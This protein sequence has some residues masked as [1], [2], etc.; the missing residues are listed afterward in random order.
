MECIEQ[1]EKSGT[2]EGS[3]FKV[4]GTSSHKLHIAPF[5]LDLPS[6][7]GRAPRRMLKKAVLVVRER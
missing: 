6:N 3:R 5:S 2:G 4:F 7:N 1:G